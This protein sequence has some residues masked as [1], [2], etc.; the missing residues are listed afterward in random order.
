MS[1]ITLRRSH[2]RLT[3]IVKNTILWKTVFIA[4]RLWFW[5][6]TRH[7]IAQAYGLALGLSSFGRKWRDDTVQES[8]TL[9]GH[10]TIECYL[11][12]AVLPSALLSKQMSTL[13]KA[14]FPV[15]PVWETVNAMSLIF[16]GTYAWVIYWRY[17]FAED[18]RSQYYVSSKVGMFD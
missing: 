5:N 12:F 1:I 14:K 11:D 8:F 16:L 7:L 3:F 2:G 10:G 18:S 4:R 6:H 15:N 17:G 13:T 9:S